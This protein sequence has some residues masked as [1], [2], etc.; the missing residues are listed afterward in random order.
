[1]FEKFSQEAIKVIMHA[2]E[3]ARVLKHPVVGCEHLLLGLIA[4]GTGLAHKVLTSHN[5]TLAGVRANV[6]TVHKKGKKVSPKELP[7]DDDAKSAL[8]RAFEEVRKSNHAQICSEHLLLGL[9][10]SPWKQNMATNLFA[11]LGV[12]PQGLRLSVIY[13]MQSEG[14]PTVIDGSCMSQEYAKWLLKQCPQ[15]FMFATTEAF[16]LKQS[17]LGSE[18]ILLGLLGAGG[19]VIRVL[20]DFGITLDLAREEISNLVGEG[21][22]QIGIDLPITPDAQKVLQAAGEEAAQLGCDTLN[23]RLLLLG[24]THVQDGIA[25]RFLREKNMDLEALRSATL[26]LFDDKK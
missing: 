15:V 25:W 19:T 3:E 16:R 17:Q 23:A 9:L 10:L 21:S 8:E 12:E 4:C 5:L 6:A 7:F 20:E 14:S 2:Q 13:A 24:F 1:M 26:A 22:G 18:M 11:S